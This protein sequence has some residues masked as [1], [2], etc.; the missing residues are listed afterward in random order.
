MTPLSLRMDQLTEDLH[1][2]AARK[3]SYALLHNIP[4][5]VA[6]VLLRKQIAR[7]YRKGG[8][9]YYA[10]QPTQQL[11]RAGPPGLDDSDYRG[12]TPFDLGKAGATGQCLGRDLHAALRHYPAGKAGA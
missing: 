2:D 12:L 11:G 1:A 10:Q 3:S 8:V 6:S 7:D 4:D 5:E 9:L